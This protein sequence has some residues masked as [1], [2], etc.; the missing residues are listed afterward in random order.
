VGRPQSKTFRSFQV[1]RCPY[2]RLSYNRFH[3]N[4]YQ[5]S[6]RQSY[7]SKH[8]QLST[9]ESSPT[10]MVG[11]N[12]LPKRRLLVLHTCRLFLPVSNTQIAVKGKQVFNYFLNFFLML[13]IRYSGLENR[14]YGRRESAA[15]T[16]RHP[17]FRKS[18]RQLRRQ[19]VGIVCS[20]TKAT[21]L[22]SD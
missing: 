8:V 17:S 7:R 21:E 1:N 3:P 13:V 9:N 18:W 16:M 12:T 14:D 20:R 4:P 6:I 19:E 5:F 15:L 22:V 2:S 10:F 11:H